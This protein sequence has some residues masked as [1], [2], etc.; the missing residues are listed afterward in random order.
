MR[1]VG[2]LATQFAPPFSLVLHYFISSVFFNFLSIL[3]LT[4]F[5]EGF[6][7]PFYIFSYAGFVHLF[8]LGFVMMT[9][10]GALY[11]LI[12]VALEVGVYSFKMGYI[13]FYLYVI[14]I[15]IMVLSMFID[16]FISLLPVG[17]TFVYISMLIFIFNFFM[18]IKNLQKK[19]ITA[20]FLI[21]ANISLFIGI[22][23]GIFLAFNFAFGFYTSFITKFIIAHIFFT[24]FGFIFMVIMGISMVLLPMFSL[25]HKFDDRY[26]KTAF[27][28][29][30]VAV[31]GGGFLV[32]FVDI[33]AIKYAVFLIFIISLLLYVAQVA[34]IYKSRPR[35][36]KDT[37]MDTMFFSH[38]FLSL[39]VIIGV[40]IPLWDIAV[41]VFASLLFLG[42]LNTLIYG[43][44]YKIIPFLTWFHRFSSLVGK[45]KVPMLGDMLPR[46]IPDF[47]IVIF[48]LGITIFTTG[49]VLSVPWIF[50]I[51][52]FLMA[53]SSLIFAYLVY[54]VLSFKLEEE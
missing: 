1:V 34:Q 25:A 4:F 53:V 43:S 6:E 31:Y 32:I 19:D 21:S 48:I 42:F 12:P 23:I 2:S 29:I 30:N 26:I 9:I 46:K 7:P 11:Q 16:R 54:Y 13:Q 37:G 44:M 22:T 39:A 28:V 41:F 20:K 14:G 40:I 35:R 33:P 15:I 47:Q 18:S 50:M 5:K 51:G 8:L 27:Y 49:M 10:F 52:V 24:V 3:A 45:K 17:G 36:T 38:I